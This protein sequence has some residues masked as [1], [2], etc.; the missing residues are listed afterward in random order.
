MKWK[1]DYLFQAFVLSV[2]K[3][4][5]GIALRNC[6]VFKGFAKTLMMA[7]CSDFYVSAGGGAWTGGWLGAH[8]HWVVPW[9]MVVRKRLRIAHNLEDQCQDK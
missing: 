9:L 1:L 3:S 8:S 6:A 7:G 4:T 2:V 5:L